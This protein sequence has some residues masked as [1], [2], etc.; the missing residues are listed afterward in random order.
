MPKHRLKHDAWL[1]VG[2]RDFAADEDV[3]EL[4]ALTLV[5]GAV[6][7]TPDAYSIH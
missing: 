2:V 1:D 3:P 4:A 7:N 5:A 6:M